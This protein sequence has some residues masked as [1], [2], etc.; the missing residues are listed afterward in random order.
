MTVRLRRIAIWTACLVGLASVWAA[1]GY[2][3]APALIRKAATERVREILHRKLEL[4]D[5]RVDPLRLRI[6][7][8]E[9]RLPDAQGG[10]MIGWRH[11]ELRLRPLRSLWLRALV[12]TE[13][14]VEG[15]QLQA[16]IDPKGE[17]NLSE[18]SLLAGPDDG[19]PAARWLI[20][21]LSVEGDAVQFTQ[22]N[23]KTS[24]VLP[25]SQL[26]LRV[27]D[28]GHAGLRQD[29]IEIRAATKDG[30]QLIVQGQLHATPLKGEA[31]LSLSKLPADTI[32]RYLDEALPFETRS[33][34]LALQGSA[35]FDGS[36]KTPAYAARLARLTLE[37]LALRAR[38]DQTDLLRLKSLTAIDGKVDSRRR[39]AALARLE[40]DG[41]DVKAWRNVD[42]SLNLSTLLGDGVAST[43]AA[44]ATSAVTRWHWSLPEF[45]VS[46]A[47]LSLED[48]GTR[49]AARVVLQEIGLRVTGLSQDAAKPLDVDLGLRVDSAGRVAAHGSAR[50]ADASFKGRVEVRDLDLRPLQPYVTQQA[51]L[52]LLS[53]RASATLDVEASSAGLNFKGDS[54]VQDLRT[55]D[56]ALRQDFVLWK[57]LRASGLDFTSAPRP[58]LHIR[59]LSA[60]APYAR[61]IVGEDRQ[62]NLSQIL[63]ARTA[64]A[65]TASQ[66][67][68]DLSIDAVHVRGGSANF[69]DLWI[70]PHFA[71]GILDLE[72]TVLGLSSQEGSRATVDLKGAVD[73]YAPVVIRGE[74]NPLSASLYSDLAMSF[75]NM[76]LTT[77]T[78]YSSRFAGYEIRKGK[79]SLDL[80]YHIKSRRLDAR[81]HV[82]LDQ[83]EL[84]DRV[85]SKDATTLP[86][87]LAIALLKDRQGVIDVQLPVTGSLDD[88]RFRIAP[89]VWRMLGNLVAK[90]VTAPFALL[91]S[92]FGGGD[93][94][95][96]L[97]FAPGTADLDEASRQRLVSLRKAMIERPG[98]RLDLP[99]AWSAEFDRPA[100]LRRQLDAQL[101]EV[102]QSAGPDRHAQLLAAWREEAGARAP[103]EGDDASL[104]QAL[105]E[106]YEV[107]E[108]E[109]E[110][111]G[112]RRALAVQDML[113]ATKEVDPVR[114]FVVEGKPAAADARQVRIDL[115]LK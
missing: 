89:L 39:D 80:D 72:G 113:F 95:N 30:A 105:L 11:A 16:T 22:Q 7:I 99:A 9:A 24:F 21:S 69:A 51:D 41:L 66:P 108:Q 43:P 56:K 49:P 63:R 44:T 58:R 53:G 42:G 20:E 75:R 64:T 102:A 74:I 100:M 68:L 48:R 101:T 67:V 52:S 110:D 45:V 62:L 3:L 25:L 13:V 77:V 81:H 47:R 31:S 92:L 28:F 6:S 33:G 17:L 97:V 83:L 98:L 115:L 73:R 15:L 91:G 78:P 88:P 104:E 61:V 82:V 111:L 93:D 87:R 114:V 103:P 70:Q 57:G 19:S 10:P 26:S 54:A 36:G 8:D 112:R 40:L 1:A 32:A 29:A 38:G 94:V 79:L 71:V 107:D 106:R 5:I 46:D 50:R 65:D 109:L 4:G 14:H 86:V 90:A 35:S 12:L 60:D 37:D 76:D 34:L 55:V 84:G 18:L 85:D 23:R 2:S 27:S 59:D 96:Q